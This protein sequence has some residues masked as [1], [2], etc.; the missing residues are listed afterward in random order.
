MSITRKP[1]GS[2]PDGRRAHLF[3]ITH[4]SG[5]SASFCDYGARLVALTVPD[6]KGVLGD[7]VWGYE[8]VSDYCR[9][10]GNAG[11]VCG[12]VAARLE[13]GAF[14]L[15]GKRWQLSRNEGENTL[16]GGFCGFDTKLWSGSPVGEDALLFSYVSQDGEEGF[17]G[18]LAVSLICR[19][20]R[21]KR[22]ILDYRA[23]TDKDTLCSLTNHSYFNLAGHGAGSALAQLVK[24]EADYYCTNGAIPMADGAIAPV[25]GTPMDFRTFSPVGRAI[26]SDFAQLRQDGGF[27]HT[28][29]LRKRER[30]ALELAASMYDSGSG[31]KMEVYTTMPGLHFFTANKTTPRTGKGGAVYD[32]Q[33]GLCFETQFFPNSAKCTWFPSPV[34]RKEN[35][36]RQVTEFRFLVSQELENQITAI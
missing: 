1:F 33:F 23:V 36:Y 16:H 31:R 14:T 20:S 28:Y 21:D 13:G 17:P 5:A 22:L 27:N 9:W 8:D 18:T 11:A 3:T 4:E 29:V 6:R 24:I 2:L 10:E 12:R 35:A 25:E 15:N 34:L 30:G 32:R 19:F 7:V 26:H